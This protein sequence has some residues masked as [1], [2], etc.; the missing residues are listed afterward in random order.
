M[1][2]ARAEDVQIDAWEALGNNGW[3]WTTLL[4]YYLKSEQFQVPKAFQV[5]NGITY[6]PNFH[7]FSGPLKTG[8]ING[9]IN[10]TIGTTFN[11]TLANLGV[12]W[13]ND[14]ND[15]TM[16]GFNSPPKTIDQDANVRE[17]AARAYY[18]PISNRTNLALYQNTY[19]NR[20]VWKSTSGCDDAVA[21]GVEVVTSNGTVAIIH[22]NKEVIVSAGALRSPL[23]LEL[24]GIGNPDILHQYDIPVVVDLPTVGENLQDQMN[25]GFTFGGN[26]TYVGSDSFIAYPTVSDLFGSNVT[27][28][29]ASIS[30]SL[31]KYADTVAK[32]S[33]NVVSAFDL[34]AFFKMQYDL[35]FNSST[36][37]I[38][39]FITPASSIFSFE[40]WILLPFSRGNIHISS[41]NATAPASINPNYFMLE[42]DTQVQI[43]GA[44]YIRNLLSTSPLSAFATGEITPSVDV[45]PVNATD[46]QYGDWVKGGFRSNFHPV[47]SAAMMSRERGGVVSERLRVYGTKNVRVVDASVLPFQVCGHLTSTLYAVAEKA[48]DLI[49]EDM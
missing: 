18:W 2:Y 11:D 35:V 43:A 10:G 26:T 20:I 47:G 4:P 40:Y 42:F 33:N 5:A 13:D 30:N 44:K 31:S 27:S 39:L 48:A 22:A 16:H 37:L 32:A 29:A 6:N 28:F 24:S 46:S 12:S 17:D 3:N 14:V 9:E 34:L 19:A 1:A 23:I 36:P 45:L 21:G 41:A 15:G 7:G 38:E 25:N 8:Y 49:K